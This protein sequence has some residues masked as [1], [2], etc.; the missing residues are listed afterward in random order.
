MSRP[1]VPPGHLAK[2]ALDS[3]M[4]TRIL[5]SPG[6]GSQNP[7]AATLLPRLPHHWPSGRRANPSGR[8]KIVRRWW[9]RER[10]RWK[11]IQLEPDGVLLS[12][13][14]RRTSRATLVLERRDRRLPGR[15]RS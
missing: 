15:S 5:L 4:R 7:S 12:E 6:R 10:A 3:V 1:A 9:V 11:W 13:R 8:R 2:P 14:S